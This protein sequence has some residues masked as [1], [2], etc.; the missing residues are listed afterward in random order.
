MEGT[1]TLKLGCG[2]SEALQPLTRQLLC[3]V[4]FFLIPGLSI[5]PDS[6]LSS[7]SSLKA[8]KHYRAL[9]GKGG[10]RLERGPGTG[11]RIQSEGLGFSVWTHL[12]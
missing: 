6:Y 9:W 1:E 2:A 7:Q 5:G 4:E 8:V 11:L 3:E 12:S 10:R